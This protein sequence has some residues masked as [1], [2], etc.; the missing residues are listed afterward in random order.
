MGVWPLLV[1]QAVIFVALILV[2]R[3]VLSQH[4]TNA[5]AHL[6]GMSSEYVR[7]HEELKKQI[8][9]AEQQYR[10]QM[11]QAKLEADRIVSQAKQEAES[12]KA[13]L[14][15]EA[16]TESERI[17][18]Q[19]METREALR[20]EIE[21]QINTR[22]IGRACELIQQALP[23]QLQQEIQS[24]WLDELIKHGL[25]PL[26]HVKAQEQ[27]KEA[28]VVS[29]CPLS[30]QQRTTLN[31]WLKERLGREVPLKET[32]DEQLVLGLTLTLGSL[33]L[34]GSLSS[35]VQRAAQQAHQANVAGGA[36]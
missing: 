11:A 22:A 2:L 21:Q 19:G 18:Q 13:T 35:K 28:K 31:T 6:Q 3:K 33:V 23:G 26:N 16:R 12:S 8:E 36:G 5:A 27:I 7:R 20:R 17:V 32:V 14:L 30:A 9:A 24:H 4:F 25:S 15:E 29:A 1:L 10:E 34:D